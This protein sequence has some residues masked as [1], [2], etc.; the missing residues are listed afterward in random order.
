MKKILVLLLMVSTYAF[1]SE[2]GHGDTDIIQRTV[3]FLLFA[4]LIWYLVAEPV[5]NYFASRSN[6][7]ADELNKVQEKLKESV[8]L[9]KEALAKIS[10]AEKFAEEL[11]IASKK[12]N[13][14]LNDN[15][16][17]QCDSDLE[18]IA[19]QHES[20]KDFETRNM[21]IEVVD[22]VISE[23]L[24]QSSEVFDRQAMANVILK[25]VA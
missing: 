21:V 22:E 3:N 1:A 24:N 14:I 20:K 25:K 15:I 10:E 16:M 19:K 9:K 7:I 11:A 23:T 4:G 5:K 2:A 8:E 13:K 18:I 6:E 17:A 12:E